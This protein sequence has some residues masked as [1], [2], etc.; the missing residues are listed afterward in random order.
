MHKPH[1]SKSRFLS[2]KNRLKDSVKTGDFTAL[3]NGRTAAERSRSFRELLQ[4]FF[5]IIGKNKRDIIWSLGFL[6][7][8]ATVGLIPPAATK[9]VFDNILG[10]QPLP[11][12]IL[13]NFPA[14]AS[15]FTLLGVI[16]I[17][18]VILALVALVFSIRGRWLA[19][20]TT[21]RIQISLRRRA[22]IHASSLPLHRVHQLRSGGAASLVREDAGAIGELVFGL[23]YNPWR[24]IIQLFGILIILLFVDWRLLLFSVVLFP[25]VFFTHRTWISRIRPLWRS[26]RGTRQF[27]DAMVTESFGGARVV[28]SFSHQRT[29]AANW[30][31]SNHLLVRKELL[32]WWLSRGIDIAWS[33]LIPVATAALLWF[34]GWQVLHDRELLAAGE[35]TAREAITAGDLVMF[36]TYLA[37]LM[38]PLATL[39]ESATQLQNSLAALDRV[40]DLFK[41]PTEQEEHDKQKTTNNKAVTVTP[42]V[43]E[44]YPTPAHTYDSDCHTPKQETTR[45]IV[46]GTINGTVTFQ[47]VSFKYPS[48]DTDV[49]HEISFIAPSGKTLALVGP[50]GSGKTTLCNLVAA[51]YNCTQ[52]NI[53]LD[54]IP[55]HEINLNSYRS[56]LGIVEQDI[57]LFEGTIASNI[58]YGKRGATSEQ[59]QSAAKQAAADTFINEFKHGYETEIGE[60][61]VKLSGGQR[62]RI[63]IARAL[64]ADPKILILDEATSNLD[65]ESERLIQHS[66]STLLKNR[67]SFV[68]AHRL[69]TIR[70]ADQILVLDKGR[71]IESGT[72]DELMARSERYH[73]M[74]VLQTQPQNSN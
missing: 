48:T 67:T 4:Q 13:L 2:F 56:L 3:S 16:A 28:R 35:I 64:L 60:R 30:I 26:I 54:S 52:G 50:S 62:Q 6:T 9:I 25:I 22:F 10:D 38:G 70:D 34:G 27:C 46:S 61:G 5:V 74:V 58:A 59:I 32:A 68:I 36:L 57:F 66:L 43:S 55:I 23:C 69:S 19:T 51:F 8:G 71:I 73:D 1:S 18:T 15:K 39:A 12:K 29:E 21:K 63:A 17:G 41:E 14:L 11:E 24:A 44:N 31:R 53:L 45:G 47:N 42:A 49:L 65:T 33:V 40:L 7:V 72:H 37:M 20:R